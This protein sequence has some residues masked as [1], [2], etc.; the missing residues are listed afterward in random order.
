MSIA[1]EDTIKQ[2]LCNNCDRNGENYKINIGRCSDVCGHDD[3]V[4]Y[5]EGGGKRMFYKKQ[6]MRKR[7]LRKTKNNKRRSNKK[8]SRRYKK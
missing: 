7:K 1:D 8:R 6:T 2:N 4:N 5:N 3:E